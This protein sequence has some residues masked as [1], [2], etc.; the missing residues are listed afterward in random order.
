MNLGRTVS[1][2]LRRKDIYEQVAKDMLEQVPYIFLEYPAITTGLSNR[3]HGFAFYPNMGQ[4][5]LANVTLG[6]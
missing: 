1:N 3:V 2:H 6:G 5:Y 4:F